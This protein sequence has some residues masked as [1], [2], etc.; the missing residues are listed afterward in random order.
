MEQLV[1]PGA[2]GD[3]TERSQEPP[4]SLPQ[5]GAG[6]NCLLSQGISPK[7]WISQ[8]TDRRGE[9]DG[10]QGNR[11]SWDTLQMGKLSQEGQNP[12]DPAGNVTCC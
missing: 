6:S 2:V 5:P 8:Q 12:K 3:T 9:Q 1:Q 4:S 11:N 7:L 10:Q